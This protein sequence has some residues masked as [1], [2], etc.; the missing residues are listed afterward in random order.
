MKTNHILTDIEFSGNSTCGN[1]YYVLDGEEYNV[2][3]E[4]SLDNDGNIRHDHWCDE[5]GNDVVKVVINVFTYDVYFNDDCDSNNKGFAQSLE[6]CKD[7]ITAYNG[8]SESY[9]ADYKGGVV[10]IVCNETGE[11]VYEEHIR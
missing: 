11:T 1:L 7:Y 10:S 4:F 6:Y 9:F 8:T 2:T 5:D 3:G